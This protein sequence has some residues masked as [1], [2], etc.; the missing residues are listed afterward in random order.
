LNWGS[1]AVDVARQIMIVPNIV[2]HTYGRLV[3]RAEAD[4][5]GLKPFTA[6]NSFHY[7]EGIHDAQAG[8][9]YAV[10]NGQFMSPLRAPC[11]QPPYGGLSAVDLKSGK[12]IWTQKLGSAQEIGPYGIASHLPINIGTPLFGGAIA[13]GGGVTFIAASQDRHFRA[14]DTATGKLLWE[15]TLHGDGAATPMSYRANGR[16]FI[17]LS[18]SGNDM[19]VQ[20]DGDFIVAYALPRS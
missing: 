14:F 16:Q 6:A 19:F 18:V 5:L 15:T 2:L 11:A 3:P 17:A 9:P 4:K 7:A 13:T 12:L 10:M 8:T 1:V 20:G